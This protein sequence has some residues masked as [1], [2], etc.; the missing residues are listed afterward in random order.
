MWFLNDPIEDLPSYTWE[1][2]EYNYRKTAA[3]SLLHPISGIM[4]S[5]PGRTGYSTA[6][7][8]GSSPILRRRMRPATRRISPG[9][10]PEAIPLCFPACS[11]C[12]AIW[13]RKNSIS[14]A[15]GILWGYVCRTAACS[16]GPSGRHCKRQKAGE[17]G[18]PWQ[19]TKIRGNPVDEEAAEA[20]MKEIGRMNR[21]CSILSR[22]MRSPRFTACRCRC[23]KYGLPVRPCSL[24]MYGGLQDIWIR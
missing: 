21:C 23:W 5:A 4:K 16:R 20:L 8:P 9:R 13:N 15:R 6:G 24:T 10:F 12:S 18:L 7:I 22:A 1:N 11:S 19:S 17:I 14:K 3:A 2:Y